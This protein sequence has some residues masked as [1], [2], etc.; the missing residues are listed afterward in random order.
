MNKEGKNEISVY[1]VKLRTGVVQSGVLQQKDVFEYCNR[2]NIIGLGWEIPNQF[3]SKELTMEEAFNTRAEKSFKDNM[4]TL[5]KIEKNDIVWVRTEDGIYYIGK[6]I[7]DEYKCWDAWEENK[8]DAEKYDIRNVKSCKFYKVGG[9]ENVPGVVV[10]SFSGQGPS[11]RRIGNEYDFKLQKEIRTICKYIF[12]KVC[13][14]TE[15]YEMNTKTDMDFWRFINDQEA[16][17]IV[18]LYLQFKKNYKVYITTKRKDTVRYEFVMVNEKGQK[19]VV[20]VKTGN[21]VTLKAEWY[22]NDTDY[23]KIFLFAIDEEISEYEK[24]NSKVEILNKE[25]I[26]RFLIEN[27]NILP[28]FIR[29]KMILCNLIK[30]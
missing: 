30:V 26:E 25:K 6:I 11:I 13:D 28:D 10:N 22:K 1:R 2:K 7:N 24:S 3:K 5:A 4:I 9:I 23:E 19:A 29:V 18:S 12:N 20:Q 8:E 16:E 27:D 17:E 14:E 21:N 15:K